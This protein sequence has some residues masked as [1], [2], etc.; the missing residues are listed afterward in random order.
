MATPRERLEGLLAEEEKVKAMLEYL[1]LEAQGRLEALVRLLPLAVKSREAWEHWLDAFKSAVR[2]V[3]F[4]PTPGVG[5]EESLRDLMG[6]L[7]WVRRDIEYLEETIEREET[8]GEK[9]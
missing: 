3:G 7:H 5:R 2:L 1:A 6:R 4:D 8:R 9:G